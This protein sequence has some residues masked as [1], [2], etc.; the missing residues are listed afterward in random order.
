MV[1]DFASFGLGSSTTTV[2]EAAALA[3][4]KNIEIKI[5]KYFHKSCLNEFVTFSAFIHASIHDKFHCCILSLTSCIRS[6]ICNCPT[7]F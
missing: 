2:P 3:S 6:S 4:T 7:V 1:L 5:H